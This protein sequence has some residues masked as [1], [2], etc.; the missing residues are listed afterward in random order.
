MNFTLIGMP[1]SG[2]SCLGR[3]LARK[4]NMVLVDTDKLIEKKYG[5]KLQALIDEVGVDKFR[6]LE[7]QTLCEVEGD[8]LIISTGGSAVYS[9]IGME[10]LRSVSQ[11]IYLYC[12]CETVIERI[13][14]YS[15]RGIVLKPGQTIRDL[16]DERTPLYERYSHHC[17][18]C[19]GKAFGRYQAN[20]IKLL[21][22]L[23]K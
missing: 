19:D 20:A 7:Q 18:N 5:M 4:L 17:L 13:G 21:Q 6:Q 3:I 9:D 16:F 11:V 1:G 15:K 14:D 12:S 23:M 8:N 22:S 10:H 2:K